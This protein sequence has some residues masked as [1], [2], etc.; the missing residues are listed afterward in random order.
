MARVFLQE[1][2]E[3]QQIEHLAGIFA[4]KEAI[5]KA[6]G[7]PFDSWYDIKIKYERS[8]RPKAE[9]FN[10]H[11]SILNSSISISHDGDYVVAYF[12]VLLP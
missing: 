7:M 1:E 12:A 3:N 2:L 4:A 10:P 11:I 9:I 6:L 5:I 8:G